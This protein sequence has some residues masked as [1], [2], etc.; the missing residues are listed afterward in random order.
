MRRWRLSCIF[1]D[2]VDREGGV[3]R[4]VRD[5]TV[6]GRRPRGRPKKTWMDNVKEDMRVLN[7]TDETAMDRERW[8]SAIA[9][10]TPPSGNN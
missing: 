10:Q 2:V 4:A 3:E 5:W 6:E 8:R 1:G 7:I 9:R